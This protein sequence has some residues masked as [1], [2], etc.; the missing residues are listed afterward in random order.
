MKSILFLKLEKVCNLLVE[1][2][3]QKNSKYQLES[4][5][6]KKVTIS[7]PLNICDTNLEIEIKNLVYWGPEHSDDFMFDINYSAK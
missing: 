6:P 2:G 1:Y 5:L 7:G 3:S 4:F